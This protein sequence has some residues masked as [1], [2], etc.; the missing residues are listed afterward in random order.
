ME[1]NFSQM[2][3]RLK[4]SEIRELLKLTRQPD[5]ISFAGGLPDPSIFPYKAVEEAA[6]QALQE[7]GELAL[8][9]SPTEGDPMLKEQLAIFMNQ[10]GEKVK[11][12]DILIVSSSQQGLDLLSKVFIDPGDPVIVEKPTYLG[13]IQS[14]RAFGTDFHG[15]EM[16][17]DGI[18]PEKVEE[19]IVKLAKEGRKPKFIYVIPDFQNPSG[20]T[21]TIERRHQL[22]ELA[23]RYDLLIVEDSPYRE[24]RFTGDLLPSLY[25]LD[26]ENRV[27][28]MKTFSKI[29]FPG[30][31]IGWVLGPEP[32]LDKMIIAKQG[33]DL[34]TAAFNSIVAA[35]VLKNGHLTRQIEVSKK[36]YS[37]KVK[38]MLDALDKYMPKL[39]GLT[40]ARPEGGMFLYIKLPEYMDAVEMFPEAVESKVAYVIGSAFNYDGSGRN[41]MRLNYSFPTEEQ[42]DTGIQ[43]LAGLIKK[44][45]EQADH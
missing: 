37:K 10:Q 28:Y 12:D 16:D 40:W 43:R 29:L 1:Y 42:I 18:I 20:I 32:V 30:F 25:S 7:K 17:F 15:V 4:R 41:T 27:L 33:T 19:I 36:R 23:S 9:Y 24:L 22:L 6:V 13:T 38:I 2:A 5:I 35:Y 26:K 14:F 44:K 31:R 45:A 8:Q 34:C 39:E 3:Q 11:A 21:L